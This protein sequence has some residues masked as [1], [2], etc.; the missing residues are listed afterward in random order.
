MGTFGGAGAGLLCPNAPNMYRI[1]WAKP[2]NEP[3]TKPFQLTTSGAWGNLTAANFTTNNWIRG[4][5][6]PAQGTRDDNMVVVNVG[7]QS[8]EIGSNR[9]AGAQAYYFSYRIK[10]TTAGGYDS[11]LTSDFNKKVLVHAY[12]GIQSERVFGFKANLLDWGPNFQSKSNTWTS[13]FLALDSN[14]L[15]GGVRLV[16]QSVTDT[17]AVVD[18]CRITE[19]GRED[20]CT[21]GLDNDCDGKV[22]G[23]DPDCA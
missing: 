14:G 12:N 3:G 7:I 20:S 16:V 8:T 6:L 1:G 10:N 11:G 4:L 23:E 22:D 18:I 21:D 15:G 13:P 19:N 2:I 5:V 9:A 17:Q